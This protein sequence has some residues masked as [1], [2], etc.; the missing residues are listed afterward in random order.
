MADEQDEVP[1]EPPSFVPNEAASAGTDKPAVASDETAPDEAESAD[2]RQ[3][4]APDG[5]DG[6]DAITKTAIDPPSGHEE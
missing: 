5:F 3:R 2:D 4:R 6:D 1:Q